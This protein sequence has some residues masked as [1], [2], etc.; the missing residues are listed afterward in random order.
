MTETI[1]LWVIAI[2]LIVGVI[3]LLHLI[4]VTKRA[5][6]VLS[7]QM[8]SLGETHLQG[9]EILTMDVDKLKAIVKELEEEVL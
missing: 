6:Q 7:I 2:G 4:A 3:A 9:L 8:K 5:E 1:A